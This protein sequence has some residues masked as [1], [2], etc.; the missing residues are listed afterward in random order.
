MAKSIHG[1]KSIQATEGIGYKIPLTMM[2]VT[3][4]AMGMVGIPGTSGF[5]AKLQ[6][7]LAF[8][9]VSRGYLVAILII[10][11]V[12][13]ALYF[14]PIIMNSFFQEDNKE[15]FKLEKIPFSMGFTLVMFVGI[16]FAL[17]LFPGLLLPYLEAAAMSLMGS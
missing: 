3:V 11:G 9:D 4:G 1:I 8:L 17:G 2:L 16:I 12:L 13:N 7:S 5:M 14:F 6:L 10:S 15:S